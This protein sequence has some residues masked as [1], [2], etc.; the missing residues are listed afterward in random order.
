MKNVTKP[1][2]PSPTLETGTNLLTLTKE[3]VKR[4]I[5]G[6]KNVKA[7]GPNRIFNE[8]IKATEHMLLSVLTDLYNK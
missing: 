2:S 6:T 4:A 5:M 1:I 7:A 8:H 3:E